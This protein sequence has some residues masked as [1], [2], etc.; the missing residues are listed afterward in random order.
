MNILFYE[1]DSSYI[2]KEVGFGKKFLGPGKPEDIILGWDLATFAKSA[3]YRYLK[4]S[5]DSRKSSNKPEFDYYD[6]I[7]ITPILLNPTVSKEIANMLQI[8]YFC[9]YKVKVSGIQISLL[10][11]IGDIDDSNR[12]ITPESVENLLSLLDIDGDYKEFFVDKTFKD[13]D[14]SKMLHLL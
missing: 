10:S 1:S 5:M 13:K 4:T 2:F 7:F 8:F 14:F 3:L 6:W 12:E 9:P 11:K